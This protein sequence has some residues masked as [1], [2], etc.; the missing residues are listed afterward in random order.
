MSNITRRNFIKLA[1]G[2]V[3]VSMLGLGFPSIAS[4]A[5]K[6]VVVVGGGCA[7]A[8]AAKYIRQGDSSIEVTL[9]EQKPHHYTC[10]MSNEV[11]GGERDMDS[12]KF[13]YDKLAGHGIK[14]VQDKA[15]AIDP[16]AHKVSTASGKA[17]EYDSRRPCGTA[18]GSTGSSLGAIRRTRP[19]SISLNPS[20]CPRREISAE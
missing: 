14:V 1:G 7:G 18:R 9:I 2:G 15:T 5:N 10:F 8:V 16:A 13:G 12:I 17:F 6:R 11:L 3:A 19:Q 20:R 4:A